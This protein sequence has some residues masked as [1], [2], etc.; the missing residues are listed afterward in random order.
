MTDMLHD[1]L[2]LCA[3]FLMKVLTNEVR[4]TQDGR[5]GEGERETYCEMGVGLRLLHEVEAWEHA[6]PIDCG[7]DFGRIRGAV[8]VEWRSIRERRLGMNG[9]SLVFPCDV[10]SERRNVVKVGHPA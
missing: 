2:R 3:L 9:S 4:P 7:V 8:S 5:L 1:Q 10:Q 6:I